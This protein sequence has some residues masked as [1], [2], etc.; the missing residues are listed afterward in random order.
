MPCGSCH[1]TTK[2][3]TNRWMLVTSDGTQ[4]FGSRLEADAAYVANGRQGTIKR[5]S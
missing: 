3:K 1:R 4:Y 2:P 5:V